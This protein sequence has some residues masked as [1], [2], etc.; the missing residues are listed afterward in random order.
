M[1][2]GVISAWTD[3][4]NSTIEAG[5]Y[6]GI[7]WKADT[8]SSV[9]YRKTTTKGTFVTSADPSTYPD[10]GCDGNLYTVRVDPT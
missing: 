1:L 6:V 7:R 5:A 3:I 4:R 8:S 2:D 9:L 10:D